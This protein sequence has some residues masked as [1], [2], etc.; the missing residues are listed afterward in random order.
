MSANLLNNTALPSITGFEANAPKLPNPKKIGNCGSFF[1]N[2]IISKKKLNHIIKTDPNI[3]YYKEQ[4]NKYKISAG[5]L[6]ENCGFKKIKIN[7]VSVYKK[8][9]LVIV[10]LGTASGENIRTFYQKIQKEVLKKYNIKLEP[11]VNI[12]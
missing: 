8:H 3:I 2:P 1:K 7:N 4:N 5:W 6:I 9:A 10:N 11:E 12:I